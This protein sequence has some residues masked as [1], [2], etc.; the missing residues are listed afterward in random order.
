MNRA[1]ASA[2][3]PAHASAHDRILGGAADQ[4]NALIEADTHIV[5]RGLRVAH[6]AGDRPLPIAIVLYH[7]IS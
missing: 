5:A 6:A 3:V 2:H 7:G 4:G 1:H